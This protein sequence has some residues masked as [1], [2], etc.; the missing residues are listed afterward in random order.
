[1]RNR[2]TDCRRYPQTQ[3]MDRSK[4]IMKK[5]DLLALLRQEAQDLR[6]PRMEA[7]LLAFGVAFS[8][9]EDGVELAAVGVDPL[10]LFEIF[11]LSVEV[12]AEVDLH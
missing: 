2:G 11:E 6:L 12:P 8:D 4:Q 9:F 10:R 3:M 7:L 1:M 5:S